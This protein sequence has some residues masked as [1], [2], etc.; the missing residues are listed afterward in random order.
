MNASDAREWVAPRMH[1]LHAVASDDQLDAL[2]GSSGIAVRF[3]AP[4]RVPTH[5]AFEGAQSSFLSVWS[6]WSTSGF[7]TRPRNVGELFTLRFVDRG[8]MVRCDDGGTEHVGLTRTAMLVAYERM[9]SEEASGDFSAL[10]GTITRSALGVGHDAL[11]GRDDRFVPDF[12][13]VVDAD[14][15]PIRTLRASLESIFRRTR[16]FQPDDFTSALL[17]E[18]LVY[19]LLSSWPRRAGAE[20]RPQATSP[21]PVLHQAVGYIEEHLASRMTLSEVAS[22]AGVSVRTLQQTFRRELDVT[23]VAYMIGR[24]LDRVR[25]DIHDPD[26]GHLTIGEIARRWGFTHQGDFGQR[27]RDRFGARPADDRRRVRSAAF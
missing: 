25:A 15:P 13:P 4:G 19:Q 27:F 14:P 10:S 2:N 7:T 24:R 23:P 18:I 8:R 6:T 11:T 9:L 20:P 5:F 3:F 17:E 26:L 16:E 1:L 22:A 12:E 21:L